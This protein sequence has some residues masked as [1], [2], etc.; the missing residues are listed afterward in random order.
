MTNTEN[1]NKSILLYTKLITEESHT[2]WNH[3][4]FYGRPATTV[5]KTQI[6][7][8]FKCDYRNTESVISQV[9]LR[10]TEIIIL[11]SFLVVN[12]YASL[13]LKKIFWEMMKELSLQHVTR[14]LWRW[15]ACTWFRPAIWRSVVMTYL[16]PPHSMAFTMGTVDMA[17]GSMVKE[18]FSTALW[19]DL[20]SWDRETVRWSWTRGDR[21][22]REQTYLRTGEWQTGSDVFSLNSAEE[23]RRSI[24]TRRL[25]PREKLREQHRVQL[26]ERVYP[27]TSVTLTL[28]PWR[29]GNRKRPVSRVQRS[30]WAD[31][32]RN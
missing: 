7:E 25:L 3:L 17:T 32:Q 5:K 28:L 18:L 20:D 22:G 15:R 11:S 14:L 27:S 21:W 30:Q 8:K 19:T 9:W 12:L 6:K 13:S 1:P 4:R 24:Q 31:R 2:D 29:P 10:G 16:G 23:R 26:Y